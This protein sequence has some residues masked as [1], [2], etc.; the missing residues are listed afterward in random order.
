MVAP[1]GNVIAF[2]TTEI[3]DLVLK[4]PNAK[5]SVRAERKPGTTEWEAVVRHY[6]PK[7]SSS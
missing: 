1:G 6:T 3:T 7:K 5:F 2:E 4:Y